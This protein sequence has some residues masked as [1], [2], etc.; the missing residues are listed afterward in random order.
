[1]E[2]LPYFVV[3]LL[4]GVCTDR[5]V[6]IIRPR[7]GVVPSFWPGVGAENSV[8]SCDRQILVYQA[9]EAVQSYRPNG[10]SAGRGSGPCGRVLI[11]R[12]MWAVGVVVLDELVQHQRQVAWPGDQHA[13]EPFAA[14]RADEALGDRVRPRCPDWGADDGNVGAGEHRVEGGGEPGITVADQEPELL[15]A[16]TEV[17]EQ[18]AGLLGDPGAGGMGGDPG[19]VYAAAAVLDHHEHV[20]AAQEDGVNVGEVDREDR[21]GLRDQELP[22]GRSGPAGSAI[23]A[24]G[25]QDLPCVLNAERGR[26]R[27]GS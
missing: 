2:R 11:E 25:L 4:S 24:V 7:V 10:R 23:D 3:D 8:T 19:E 14:Q 17:D 27:S 9:T 13:G 20:E 1:V 22:A 15:G 12:S 26:C 18:V 21:L 5:G 6:L 16:V